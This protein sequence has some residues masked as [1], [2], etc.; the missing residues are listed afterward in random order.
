[1]PTASIEQRW[2]ELERLRENEIIRNASSRDS[3]LVDERY[4]QR[5][6]EGEQSDPVGTN[7]ENRSIMMNTDAVHRLKENFPGLGRFFS[8]KPRRPTSNSSD[9]DRLEPSNAW[10]E[11]TNHNSDHEKDGE[12]INTKKGLQN[13]EDVKPASEKSLRR[14]DVFSKAHK[15]PHRH[16]NDLLAV[17][18]DIPSGTT[19]LGLLHMAESS[20]KQAD[21]FIDH[22]ERPDLAL[23]EW[24]KVTFITESII[25]DCQEYSSL[26]NDPGLL[27]RYNMIKTW[28]VENFGKI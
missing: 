19:I 20:S 14:D 24:A 15:R 21:T 11:P 3:T 13:Q 1:M 17:K 27:A 16:L 12:G 9:W 25:P 4:Q 7:L 26:M 5:Q 23:Q 8:T 18:P 10:L 28:L 22:L 2:E 6:T